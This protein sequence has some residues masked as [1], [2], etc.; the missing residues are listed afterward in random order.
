MPNTGSTSKCKLTTV[1]SGS[2]TAH[3]G[4]G[5][6]GM[7][8]KDERKVLAVLGLFYILLMLMFM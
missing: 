5:E 7:T 3:G 4:S 8:L 6:H 2:A 1:K